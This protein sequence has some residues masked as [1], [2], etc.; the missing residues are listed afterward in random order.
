MK[1]IEYRIFNLSEGGKILP[2]GKKLSW[3][4][5]L[6]QYGQDG[7]EVII[8]LNKASFQIWQAIRVR[9]ILLLLPA[10]VPGRIPG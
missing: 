6:N 2:D 7:W 4:D 9:L 1:K 10:E 3:L 5:V 8:H